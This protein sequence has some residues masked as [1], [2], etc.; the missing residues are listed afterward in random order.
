MVVGEGHALAAAHMYRIEDNFQELLLTFHLVGSENQ[1]RVVIRLGGK[2]LFFFFLPLSYLFYSLEGLLGIELKPLVCWARAI[3][4][5]T[6]KPHQ[7][8]L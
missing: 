2:N 4:G 7:L 5:A 1:S 8:D 3:P 6:P